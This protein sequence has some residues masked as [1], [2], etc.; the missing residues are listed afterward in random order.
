M[1]HSGNGWSCP[2]CGSVIVDKPAASEP[3]Q[4]EQDR[5]NSSPVPAR[6]IRSLNAT[7]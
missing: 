6:E 5:G 2:Q 7:A 3:K 4:R 1:V